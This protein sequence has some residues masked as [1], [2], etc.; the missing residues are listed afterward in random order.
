[1]VLS[2]SN[3]EILST[4]LSAGLAGW[5]SKE[6]NFV[7]EDEI[8][9][10]QKILHEYEVPETARKIIASATSDEYNVALQFPDKLLIYAPL[11]CEG[12]RLYTEQ[13]L[14]N[15]NQHHLKNIF[16]FI[17]GDTSY[18]ECCV[19]EV[20]SQHLSANL[21][22]HYGNACLSPSRTIPVL[23]I[24]PKYEFQNAELCCKKVKSIVS[25]AVSNTEA[26]QIVILFDLDLHA[27][28]HHDRFEID[29]NYVKFTELNLSKDI[30]VASLR[31]KNPGKVLQPSSQSWECSEN[32]IPVGVLSFDPISIPLSKTTFLWITTKS[33]NNDWSVPIRN[34]ALQLS[35]GSGETCFEFLCASLDENAN[36]EMRIV[37]ATRIL[38]KR[39]AQL[40][41]AKSAERIGIIAGTL[42]VS[43][44]TEVIERCKKV[45][46]AADKRCYI[47]LVGKINPAKLANFPE[48]DVF[49][50][51]SC[52]QNILFDGRDYFQP[53]ITPLELEAA[54]LRDGDIFTDSYSADFRELL[55]RELGELTTE[56]DDNVEGNEGQ[57]STSITERGDWT[58]SV[59][60]N[61]AG[62]DFLKQRSWQGLKYDAGGADDDTDI[63]ELSL[64][65]MQGQSGI[66]SGYDRE[67]DL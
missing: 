20:A 64:N 13:Y 23:Y 8:G 43:G 47:M 63:A 61:S 31:L 50:L 48:I 5:L 30:N 35:T 4:E 53:V 37:N 67:K 28:F 49:V 44:N 41:K 42:G 7:D 59:S 33:Y 14:R 34:A 6:H 15:E 66:A 3:D 22:V 55:S 52:P 26:E 27:Y 18:G 29:D 16:C 46:K 17:L 60:G 39:Y 38:R 57:T 25:N 11:V 45:I 54:L 21:I 1:M 40:E 32:E 65:I 9:A 58:V 12:L 2:L 36:S 62:A 19:D 24:L 10:I 51:V 56:N